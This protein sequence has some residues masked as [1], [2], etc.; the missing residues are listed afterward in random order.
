MV[1]PLKRANRIWTKISHMGNK[2]MWEHLA[3]SVPIYTFS[4]EPT[5]SDI[6][7]P[8]FL[9]ITHKALNLLYWRGSGWISKE[10]HHAPSPILS[11]HTSK[12]A[13]KSSCTLGS[14]CRP[15]QMSSR[16]QRL[17]VLCKLY[18]IYNLSNQFSY[19]LLYSQHILRFVH[20]G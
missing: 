9:C 3:L 6:I 4:N 19:L 7:T 18:I 13:L 11:Q 1:L 12:I 10:T 16:K 5:K 14:M 20:H 8:D 15:K 17:V 2:A